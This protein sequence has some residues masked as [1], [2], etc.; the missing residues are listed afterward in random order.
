LSPAEFGA[1]AIV[2]SVISVSTIFV[3]LGFRS[4][5]VRASELSQQQLSTVF[6]VNLLLAVLLFGFFASIAGIIERFYEIDGLASYVIAASLTFGINAA[7]VVPGG[8]LQRELQLRLLAIVNAAAAFISGGIAIYLA[9]SGIGVWTLVVQQ[10]VSAACVLLGTAAFARWLPSPS[11]D[12][13]SIRSLWSYGSKLFASGIADTAFLRMDVFIIGK[14][15]PIQI[16]G[17]YNR[18]QGLDSLIKTF[19]ASTATSVAFPVIA[20]MADDTAN[21]R[22]FY[23]RCMNVI[24]FLSFMLIGILFLGCFDIV[25]IL[26][27]DKWAMVGNYFRIMA[28]TG[29]VYPISALMVNL[30][31]ARGN[32]QA[33]LK[34]ELL[35]KAILFPTYLSFLVGG[36]YVFLIVL[37]AAYLAALVLNAKFVKDEISISLNDQL[38]PVATYAV[39]AAV[40]VSVVFGITYK[41]DNTYLHLVAAS[42]LFTAAYL[43]ICHRFKLPGFI[44]I[45]Y[46]LLN[47]YNAK[48][49]PDISPT[50]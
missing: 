50:T 16:L 32:S 26:F 8:L 3:D 14:L 49:H 38:G 37:S 42:G 23:T 29:F 40:A 27:T 18:A 13:D 22:V 24:A 5:I 4:A 36:V 48:R 17:F 9:I 7:A 31:A 25:I 1:F 44:E 46:R 10:I 34:L 21:V 30:I 11:F 28:L 43:F 20:R 6:Y 39:A 33:Y 19:S 45:Y 35:K 2:L 12:L 41:I 15:F 47:F